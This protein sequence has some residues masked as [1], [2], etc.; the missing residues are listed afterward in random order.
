MDIQKRKKVWQL[1]AVSL[2]LTIITGYTI[3]LGLPKPAKAEMLA[4][5][6]LA[7]QQEEDAGQE[8]GRE[9][10]Q[11]N[12]QTDPQELSEGPM[13]SEGTEIAE[14]EISVAYMIS[15]FPIIYQMPELPT[16]CE[17]TPAAMVL[18]YYGFQVDKTVLAE[19][20]LPTLYSTGIYYGQDGRTYGNDMNAYFIGDPRTE[21]GIIC[22]TGAIVTALNS[23]LSDIRS[24]MRAADLTGAAPEE[25]YRLVSEDVP[26]VV[27]CT[28]GMA[29]RGSTQG[30]YTESGEYVDW[31]SN[32][33]GAVLI[34]YGP[35][36]VTIADPISG[37]VEYSREQFESVFA[38]R[39]YQCVIIQEEVV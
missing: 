33:H 9:A 19:Q 32:D 6:E 12:A 18:N 14:I 25:L 35:D 1:A 22:G 28:I 13:A 29:D 31:A 21:N 26:V 37:L 8:S 24:S 34:G 2:F 27:W 39:S 38:A 5:G 30:W 4:E 7:A 3:D 17:I 11:G 23:C 15:D 16:G 20:Y 10:G 36:T